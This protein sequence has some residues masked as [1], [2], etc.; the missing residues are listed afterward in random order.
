MKEGEISSFN[1]SYMHSFLRRAWHTNYAQ[2]VFNEWIHMGKYL[3]EVYGRGVQVVE[4]G[5]GMLMK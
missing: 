4:A 3:K 5:E 1:S 2:Y